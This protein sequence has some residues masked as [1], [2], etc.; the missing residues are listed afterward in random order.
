[1]ALLTNGEI[2]NFNV[3]AIESIINQLNSLK[4]N[5]KHHT[6]TKQV[7]VTTLTHMYKVKVMMVSLRVN[8]PKIYRPIFCSLDKTY[9]GLC[10]GREWEYFCHCS[11]SQRLDSTE[12]KAHFLSKHF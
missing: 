10:P 2:I 11:S 6:Q 9:S 1:M 7:P 8:L 3:I 12:I 5:S 4:L